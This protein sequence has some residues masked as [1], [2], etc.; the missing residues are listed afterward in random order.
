MDWNAAMED[1]RR[2]LKRI[3]ALLYALAGLA[4]RLYDLSRPARGLV[5][6]VLRSAETVAR[7]F[8][9]D[10]A[11]EHGAS[12]APAFLLIPALHGGDSPADAMRLANSFRALAVL[13]DRLADENPGHHRI[14]ITKL[15]IALAACAADGHLSAGTRFGRRQPCLAPRGFAVERRDS[16]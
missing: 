4:E 6:W 14:C 16:S 12:A 2:M 15:C 10:T 9:I 13:L 3:V 7:D 11:L 8:V 5:L 1:N